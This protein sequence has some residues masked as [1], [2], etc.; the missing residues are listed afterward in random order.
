MLS[1]INLPN[2][3]FI[4]SCILLILLGTIIT[5]LIL[6]YI[7][8]ISYIKNKRLYIDTFSYSSIC[9]IIIGRIFIVII[10]ML[11]GWQ[12]ESIFFVAYLITLVIISFYVI[13][14]N[15]NKIVA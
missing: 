3:T 6:K 11:T 8:K 2:V 9:G 4:L 15:K 5:F 12:S 14:Y 1:R 10:G 7:Y 13:N